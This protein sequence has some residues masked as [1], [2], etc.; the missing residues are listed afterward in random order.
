MILQNLGACYLEGN[1]FSQSE[2]SEKYVN[3]QEVEIWH[4]MKTCLIKSSSLVEVWPVWCGVGQKRGS[5][6]STEKLLAFIGWDKY[7]PK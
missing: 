4:K 7:T 1:V 2:E 5:R 3:Y 6:G